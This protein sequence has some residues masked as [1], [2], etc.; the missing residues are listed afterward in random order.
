MDKKKRRSITG[1]ILLILVIFAI[2]LDVSMPMQA[3]AKSEGKD[4]LDIVNFSMSK[5]APLT[6]GIPLGISAKGTG[7]SGSYRYKFCVIDKEENVAVY[8]RDY[9]REN[10]ATWLP[11]KQGNYEIYVFVKDVSS[12]EIISSVKEFQIVR[13][14]AVKKI[15]IVKR[16]EKTVLFRIKAS[17][18][19]R[20]QYKIVAKRIKGKSITIKKYDRNTVYKY[21][22][23]KAGT[24]AISFY[25]KDG[26]GAEKLQKKKLVVK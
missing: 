3:A 9:A 22:F 21:K 4:T 6:A 15:Q 11:K 10:K 14:I 19:G 23:K 2:V 24:Y 13:A 20:L 17:G 16:K 26:N 1:L 5:Y 8:Y 18:Y 12:G 25:I 7:G